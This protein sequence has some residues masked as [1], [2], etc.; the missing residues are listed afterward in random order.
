MRPQRALRSAGGAAGVEDRRVV[1]GGEVDPGQR[2]L[3]QRRPV[4]RRPDR[5]LEPAGALVTG[6]VL[7]TRR[8]IPLSAALMVGGCG[9]FMLCLLLVGLAGS[10]PVASGVPDAAGSA[11]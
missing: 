3:G 7:S 2:R 1:V 11:S 5:I 8:G 6:L 10:L 4:M 9:F